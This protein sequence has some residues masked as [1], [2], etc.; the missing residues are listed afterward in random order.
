MKR[1]CVWS[2]RGGGSLAAWALAQ[3][4]QQVQQPVGTMFQLWLKKLP[5]SSV[6]VHAQD[7]DTVCECWRKNS[8]GSGHA[9]GMMI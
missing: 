2:L 3:Q 9:I 4:T 7:F 5:T 8:A 6:V 1:T